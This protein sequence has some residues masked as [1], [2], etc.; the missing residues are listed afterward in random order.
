MKAIK[1]NVGDALLIVKTYDTLQRVKT[2]K[3][4]EPL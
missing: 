2:F 3:C 4:L 1:V